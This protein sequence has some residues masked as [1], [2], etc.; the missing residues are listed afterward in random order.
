MVQTTWDDVNA[1]LSSEAKVEQPGGQPSKLETALD[2]IITTAITES[3][4]HTA[5]IPEKEESQKP[6]DLPLAEDEEI[7]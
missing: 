4:G 5:D 2:E 6:Q 1:Q 7:S 3:E